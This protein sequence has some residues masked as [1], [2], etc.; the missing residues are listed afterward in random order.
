MDF[1]QAQADAQRRTSIF[2]V[3]FIAAVVSIILVIYGI[4]HFALTFDMRS[5]FQPKLF[6]WIAGGVIL[7]VG[8]GSLH[9]IM[10]LR[11]GGE[12]VAELLGGRRVQPNSEDPGERRL[13]N[14]V[15]E[16]A[17]A[18]GVPVPAIFILDREEGINAFAAGHS[19][20][21]AAIGITRGALEH[22][23][24]DELQGVIA[25]EF[26]HIL[27]GDMRLN[28]RIMGLIYGILLLTVVGRVILEFGASGSRGRRKNDGT[29]YVVL[30]GAAL[31]L[32][33]YI[34]VF[35]GRL[36]Q[37]AISR[38]R[39]FLADAAAVQFTRNPAGIAG[40]LKV[41]G[42]HAESSRIMAPHAVEAGH[43]FFANRARSFFGGF[44]ATHPPLVTRIRRIE[45]SFDGRFDRIPRR[46]P[47]RPA[48]EP[49]PSGGSGGAGVKDFIEA[50]GTPTPDHLDHASTLL[51][52]IP[53][54]I[55]LAARSP[56][57]LP[58]LLF[59]LLYHPES[60]AADRAENAIISFGGEAALERTR[61][62]AEDLHGAR[63]IR[64]TLL[65]LA[66]PTARELPREEIEKL[67]DAVDRVTAA[68]PVSDP[69]GH[70]VAQHLA[71]KIGQETKR[72]AHKV[73]HNLAP[74]RAPLEIVLS[75]LAYS[76]AD[77]EF[78]ARDAL[79]AAVGSLPDDYG[80]PVLR[81]RDRT[82]PTAVRDALDR[83]AAG[84]IA[85]RRQ[86]L[87]CAASVV[88]ADGVIRDEEAEL[89]QAI[90]AALDCP[91]PP[92]V[93]EPAAARL[94]AE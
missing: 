51:A 59:A 23:S 67:I 91:V 32:V 22:L 42:A 61:S 56:A 64:F 73:V 44:F 40:A 84:S 35:F 89:L 86:I 30:I 66:L 52:A 7:L 21:D 74:L 48:P 94:A 19:I 27:N 50:V 43:F 26:S 9:L 34:G 63:T 75:A 17:I 53:E 68:G 60:A 36:I 62:L 8:G 80:E 92:L 70:V 11:R 76:G 78:A 33:G 1:F 46:I 15:E 90:A 58:A 79:A 81:S 28:I 39:E 13:I 6:A 31:I 49:A 18:S 41:I 12:A 2:V 47:P 10:K 87:T 72:P 65:E 77:D 54:P 55:R 37:A 82:S 88:A 4:A 14:V 71:R 83:L 85:V 3:L 25:H 5:P 38:Q 45:P 69:F 20:H 57:D 24:R 93:A 16:M 29:A